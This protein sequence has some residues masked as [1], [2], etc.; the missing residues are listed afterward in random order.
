MPTA[1]PSS[2]PGA[3]PAGSS[4]APAGK[5]AGEG[6]RFP[7]RAGSAAARRIWFVNRFFWPDHSATSQMVSDLAFHLA[8]RGHDVGVIASRG[9]YAGPGADLPRVESRNG[10][11]IHRVVQPRFGRGSLSGRGLDYVSLYVAFAA[12][13]WRLAKPGDVVVAKTDPPLLSCVV[14]PVAGARRLVQVNWL[15]DLY[16]EVALRLGVNALK[17]IA[18]ALTAARNASLRASARNV[19]IGETMSRR[20]LGG[21]VAPE[22]VAVI[23]NWTDDNSVRPVA[24]EANTLR[25]EWGLQDKFVV[26]YSGNLGRAHEY[27]TLMTAA[28]LLRNDAEIVFLFIGGGHH[29]EQLKGE[30]QRRNLADKFQFRPYQDS[31]ALASSLSAPDVHWISLVP[32]MEGLIVPSKFYGVAAAGRPTIAVSDPDG[33]IGAIVRRF[34]CGLAVSPGDGP[35]LAAAIRSLKADPSRR[36]TMGANARALIEGRFARAHALAQWESLLAQI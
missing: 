17:P 8:S 19:A 16:P 1:T 25:A 7:E 29:V 20:L 22:R 5:A 2:A 33:E 27:E 23:H 13:L 36:A 10:V 34:D 24:R 35:G 4:G 31:S 14:S 18:P 9:L 3:S 6:T 26:G 30:I 12:A 28:E 15:Q 11:S 32:D 21:G